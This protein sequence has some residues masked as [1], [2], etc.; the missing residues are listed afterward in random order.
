MGRTTLTVGE[1]REALEE[2]DDDIPVVVLGHKTW[3]IRAQT[4]Y[5]AAFADFDYCKS[6]VNE[7]PV[8]LALTVVD[9]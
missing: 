9:G 1:L 2:L 3:V 5:Q 6:E 7:K 4:V 8:A